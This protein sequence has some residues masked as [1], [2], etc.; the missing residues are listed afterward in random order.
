MTSIICVFAQDCV[1]MSECD[2]FLSVQ[3]GK[4]SKYKVCAYSGLVPTL[5]F[6]SVSLQVICPFCLFC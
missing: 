6:N 4:G 5:W 2:C 3:V 1:L